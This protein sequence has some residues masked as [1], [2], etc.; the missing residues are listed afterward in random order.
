[1]KTFGGF[2]RYSANGLSLGQGAIRTTR[3]AARI[4]MPIPLG[5][6]PPWAFGI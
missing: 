5:L 6:L 1:M 4:W 3:L 2:L